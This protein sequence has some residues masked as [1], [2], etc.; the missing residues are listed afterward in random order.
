MESVPAKGDAYTR[1]EIAFKL[2]AHL[3]SLGFAIPPSKR[4]PEPQPEPQG[5]PGDSEDEAQDD[6]EE[7]QS[8]PKGHGSTK[9][10][11]AGDDESEDS[12][13]EGDSQDESNESEK[14]EVDELPHMSQ[15]GDEE[16]DPSAQSDPQAGDDDEGEDGDDDPEDDQDDQAGKGE[17]ADPED[18]DEGDKPEGDDEGDASDDDGDEEFPAGKGGDEADDDDEES[19]MDEE[20]GKQDEESGPTPEEL[21]QQAA[22][23]VAKAMR[24][25]MGHEDKEQEDGNYTDPEDGFQPHPDDADAKAQEALDEAIRW[26][27]F[28]TPPTGIKD[29]Y[30]SAPDLESY[31]AKYYDRPDLDPGLVS[32]ETAR[33]RTVFAL[34]RK[35]RL[36]GS[37]KSGSRLDVPN[38]HRIGQDDFRIFAKKDRPARRDWFVLVGLDDSGSTHSNGAAEVIREMGLGIGEMLNGVGV[39]F[40]IYG[41]GGTA[42][43]MTPVTS[44]GWS[45]RHLVVKGPDEP[46]TNEC[47]DRLKFLGRDN[48]CNYDGHS[49]EQYRKVLDKRHETDKMLLYVTDGAMP[50][51]NFAEELEVLKREI[52]NLQQR[53]VNLFGVGYRT[54]SPKQHGMDTLVIQDG[55]DLP[56]LI[57]GLRSRLES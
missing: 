12:E 29:F 20:D 43:S 51:M 45:V 53:K 26:Q 50:M 9:G 15:G 48:T 21:D 19:S 31:E 6:D 42:P 11:E 7:P 1:G 24:Q 3:R 52:R 17:Q 33:L 39:K 57:D 16:E 56:G 49:L 13:T 55:R 27:K 8:G 4:E 10:E 54:D 38:L 22:E 35:T 36:T 34:N 40:A 28:D 44:N 30:E 23:E 2:L 18:D 14:D 37:L 25:F 46:W 41:H 5:D 47:K 32:G